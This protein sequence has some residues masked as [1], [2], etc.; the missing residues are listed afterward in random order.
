VGNIIW[1][2]TCISIRFSPYFRVVEAFFVR[3][4]FITR[5]KKHA[6]MI[7]EASDLPHNTPHAKQNNYRDAH[8][9]FQDQV[10]EN[11]TRAA[12]TEHSQATVT[13]G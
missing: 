9:H 3:S 2:L 4:K 7:L 1:L 12:S 5:C 13:A 11:E 10:Y 8:K 6:E